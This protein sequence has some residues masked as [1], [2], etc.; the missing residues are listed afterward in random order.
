M[1]Y[2]REVMPAILLFKLTYERPLTRLIGTSCSLCL[3]ILAS[4]T[5]FV[6]R[7]SRFSTRK[8]ERSREKRLEEKEVEG[9]NREGSRGGE[10]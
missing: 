6:L 1:F 5:R 2:P 4:G 8:I 7:S 10:E 9:K 3:S